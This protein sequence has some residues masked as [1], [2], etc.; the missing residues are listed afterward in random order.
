MFRK[1]PRLG[2]ARETSPSPSQF[3]ASIHFT[4]FQLRPVISH[5]F[6]W[7]RLSREVETSQ[8]QISQI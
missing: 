6:V 4:E 5:G 1:Q 2:H 8:M 7:S 3:V